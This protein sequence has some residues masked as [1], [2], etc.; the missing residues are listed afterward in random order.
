MREG[1]FA[2][3]GDL[4]AL[5]LIF[6]A[7]AFLWWFISTRYSPIWLAA[8]VIVFVLI[9]LLYFARLVPSLESAAGQP[10]GERVGAQTK[11]RMP[12]FLSGRETL[13]ATRMFEFPVAEHWPI[14]FDGPAVFHRAS[15]FTPP[16]VGTPIGALGN[17][18]THF[19]RLRT[20]HELVTKTG[21]RETL[22][23][24]L[25]VSRPILEVVPRSDIE[26]TTDGLLLVLRSAAGTHGGLAG[27]SEDAVEPTGR[28][29]S[30]AGEILDV[31]Y[32]GHSV[33]VKFRALEE[34]VLIYRDNAAPGWSV[35][36]DGKP[37]D[38]LVVDR[39]NKAVAVPGGLH[40]VTFV[41]RPWMYLGAFALRVATLFIAG[42]AC[43]GVALRRR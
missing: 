23:E 16:V 12:S 27:E 39:V 20:Y 31:A 40:Q 13:P 29:V 37:A 10:L 4:G 26:S 24:I 25:G 17:E 32:E 22:A 15:A 21:N 35:H 41:Y 33:T 7:L 9:E 3:P 30:P 14:H 34:A 19:F 36:V 8:P 1:S 38:L 42:L 18:Y 5:S 11:A 2:V 43:M 28:P 6:A